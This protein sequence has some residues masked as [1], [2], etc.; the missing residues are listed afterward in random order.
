MVKMFILNLLVAAIGNKEEFCGEQC[1][2]DEDLVQADQ[3]RDMWVPP[4]RYC[5][6]AE[7]LDIWVDGYE[8]GPGGNCIEAFWIQKIGGVERKVSSCIYETNFMIFD[9]GQTLDDPEIIDCMSEPASDLTH[10]MSAQ[11]DTKGR[12]HEDL[13]NN[14]DVVSS[15]AYA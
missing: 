9:Y 13:P 10:A 7:G 8:F 3:Q 11:E 14:S 2:E 1:M 5:I 6:R 12:S 4:A 15:S